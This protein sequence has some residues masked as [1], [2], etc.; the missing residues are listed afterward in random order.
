MMDTSFSRYLEFVR[1]D[2]TVEMSIPVYRS[3]VETLRRIAASDGC[4]C[5][6]RVKGRKAHASSCPV[7]SAR[8]CLDEVR[9]L[10][11]LPN[12]LIDR[13]D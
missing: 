8:V 9:W 13:E 2:G 3:L 12:Y 11:S 10:S 4:S 1:D 6:E 7:V 5:Q